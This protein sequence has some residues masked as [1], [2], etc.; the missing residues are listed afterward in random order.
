MYNNQI[1]K[2]SVLQSNCYR[3]V[4]LQCTP[5]YKLTTQRAEWSKY[6]HLWTAMASGSMSLK[7]N[8]LEIE[9]LTHT[10]N[11]IVTHCKQCK[12]NLAH[13]SHSEIVD[14]V[15]QKRINIGHSTDR[16]RLVEV[17]CSPRCCRRPDSLTCSSYWY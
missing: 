14:I 7:P 8:Q 9:L 1:I 17:V 16:S 15:Q 2:Y 13:T 6:C 5:H 10:P 11:T 4:V 3:Q 12:P